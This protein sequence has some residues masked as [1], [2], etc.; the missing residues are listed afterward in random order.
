MSQK[1]KKRK[2]RRDRLPTSV[3][4]GD[5]FWVLTNESTSMEPTM[6]SME[7]ADDVYSRVDTVKYCYRMICECGRVRF[8]KPNTIHEVTRCR[9]CRRLERR[10]QKRASASKATSTTVAGAGETGETGETGEGNE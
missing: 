9:P 6:A 1:E 8:A 7:G 3:L 2:W 5:I 4:V 10:S